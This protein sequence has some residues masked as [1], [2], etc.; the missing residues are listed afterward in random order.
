M[1][2]QLLLA[3]QLQLW[4]SKTRLGSSKHAEALNWRLR[5]QTKQKTRLN[6]NKMSFGQFAAAQQTSLK[7]FKEVIF[8]FFLE[9]NFWC[10]IIKAIRPVLLLHPSIYP[11]PVCLL[12]RK[13]TWLSFLSGKHSF[14]TNLL[15]FL[16]Y[17]LLV[18]RAWE[19]FYSYFQARRWQCHIL[20]DCTTSVVVRDC[21]LLFTKPAD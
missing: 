6:S 20:V 2:A 17:P 13:Y 21:Q 18:T 15:V 1:S 4:F 11:L 10:F 14:W 9:I 5:Q 7:R 8:N 16:Q 19:T 3:E 12:W